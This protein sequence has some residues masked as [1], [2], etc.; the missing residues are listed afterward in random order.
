[1]AVCGGEG[2]FTSM[3]MLGL[4]NANFKLIGVSIWA[5]GLITTLLYSNFFIDYLVVNEW[6]N[7]SGYTRII[8]PD[9]FLY[10]SILDGNSLVSLLNIGIK[11]TIGPS[12]LWYLTD[13]NWYL[14]IFLNWLMIGLIA[15]YIV[16]ISNIYSIS[17]TQIQVAALLFLLSP[18]CAY[19]SVGALKEIPT[20]LLLLIYVRGILTGSKWSVIVSS[21][22]LILFR[23]Q[24][25]VVIGLIYILALRKKTILRNSIIIMLLL[26]A[27][28]P[29]L[30]GN[31]LLSSEAT[32][33]Y[34]ETYGVQGSIGS[35]IELLR[36]NYPVLSI[37]GV[38]IRVLQTILEPILTLL[39]SG[40]Y[41]DESLSVYAVAHVTGF[42]LVIGYIYM[43]LKKLFYMIRR[44]GKV[45]SDI[46]FL[47]TLLF[48]FLVLIG[49]FSFIHQRYII[50]LFPL[51]MIA[52]M[53]PI[54]PTKRYTHS[55]SASKDVQPDL[56]PLTLRIEH[57]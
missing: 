44:P 34:R 10:L 42:F 16:K 4:S 17:T 7:V 38:L 21:I 29:F 37:V 6:L 49:G 54:R 33:S 52:A 46:S 11:N 26:I 48:I 41:E 43:Y 20:T 30:Q 2:A 13:G 12:L 18:T 8:I 36:N 39:R 57:P 25:A 28:Y 24:L 32:L 56:Q 51:I 19:Y 23:Y 40:F 14:M 5:I 27:I 3:K 31:N 9:T 53:I 55:F 1:V 22:L 35:Y 15:I 47:Y 45:N 50:P